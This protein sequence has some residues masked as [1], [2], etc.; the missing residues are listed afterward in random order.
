MAG[1]YDYIPLDKSWII[2]MGVLDITNS[3][4]DIREFI[5]KQEDLGDDL[6]AL[7]RISKNWDS[8]NPLDIGESGTLYRFIR[9]ATW[10]LEKKNELIKRGTLKDRKM[11][12]NPEIVNWPLEKLLTLDGGTSQWATAAILMGS[13]EKIEEPDDKIQLAYGAV[14]HWNK[15]RIFHGNW[16]PRY[17]K[18]INRQAAYFVDALRKG[19]REIN[20]VPWRSEDYC[21]AR[22]FEAISKE[23]GKELFP[24]IV[25]HESNRIKEMEKVIKSANNDEYI[26]SKD[27][28]VVQAYAM[29]QLFFGNEIKVKNKNAVNKS[30]PQFWDF[31]EYAKGLKKN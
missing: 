5:E 13:T 21:F 30:W 3:Y 19:L 22:A 8:N 27:H 15:K 2:R 18:T 17:D 12:D 6:K 14:S 7:G 16:E 20:L 25:N 10:K 11:C 29:R 31:M 28:R 24:Q 9:F 1:I 4:K 26:D 23:R